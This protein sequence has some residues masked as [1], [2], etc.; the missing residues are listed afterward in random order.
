[1]PAACPTPRAR[2]LLAGLVGLLVAVGLAAAVPAAQ[3]ASGEAP[4]RRAGHQL[5]VDPGSQAA[6][7]GVRRIARQPQAFWLLDHHSVATVR[8]VVR[9]Y[10]DTAARAGRR[11]V[12]AVYAIPDRDCDGYSSGGLADDDAYR[13]WIRQVATGLRARRAVV[14]LEPD[15]LASIGGTTC[16][17]Q[18][19]RL[20]LLA[21]AVR[22]LAR[23]GAW[24]YLDA[25]H[26][27]WQPADRTAR[28]LRT[29]G[30]AK[31]RGFSTNVSNF[32][33]LRA[34]RAWA[35]QVR[36]QLDRLGVRGV[37]YVV[38]TSRNGARPRSSEWCNPPWARL[39]RPPALVRQGA[40]D[41]RLWVKRPGESDGPCQGGPAAGV[42][43][44][45]LARRLMR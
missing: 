5:Y 39:G 43:S 14:V 40:F 23:A 11:P 7:H 20:G 25:G 30:V 26:S 13:A 2:P 16:S 31:A 19:D 45:E 3:S 35:Q 28:L 10:A 41:G 21:D 38:D 32:R 24:V 6:Q 8:D 17:G 42:W 36:G 15:A 4:H 27:N 29:A 22:V 33:P 18:G 34:E 12:F 37:K 9:R 44:D 1:M